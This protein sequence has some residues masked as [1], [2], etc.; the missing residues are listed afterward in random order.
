LRPLLADGRIRTLSLE[1]NVFDKQDA[2]DLASWPE[3]RR[4]HEL[5]LGYFNHVGDDGRK[6]L[7][8]SPHRHPYSRYG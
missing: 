7:E 1:H 2:L 6:S 4:L 3:L 5:S 8:E